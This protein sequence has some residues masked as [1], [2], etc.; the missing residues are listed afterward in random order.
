MVQYEFQLLP[1]LI[2][3]SLYNTFD[4]QSQL[5]I[6]LKLNKFACTSLWK[7]KLEKGK[8]EDINGNITAHIGTRITCELAA[9]VNVSA[10]SQEISE[11]ENHKSDNN[12]HG[13][14]KS[15]SDDS[16]KW[17]NKQCEFYRKNK[18]IS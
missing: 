7:E 3:L 8:C 6:C 9:H 14:V 12:I 10:I 18:S 17:L 4:I 1:E 13:P 5:K 2:F 15:D 11:K 16:S